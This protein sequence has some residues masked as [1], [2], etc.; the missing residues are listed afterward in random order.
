MVLG[1]R[2]TKD[3][4]DPRFK[5]FH[6]LMRK[7]IHDILLVSTLYDACI[8]EEDG[9]LA[10]RIF[11]EYRGL[12]LSQPPRLT[13]ASSGEEALRCLDEKEFDLVL[14]MRRLADMDSYAFGE[15]LKRKRPGLPVIL[16]THTA[17]DP[18]RL[19][20]RPPGIDRTFVWTGNDELLL[21]LVKSVEDQMNVDHDIEVAG[22]RVILFVEDSPLYLS[23]LLPVVFK[24]VMLQTQAVMEQGLNEEHKLLTMRARPKILVAE[25]F[26]EATGLYE[27]Y[28]QYLLG[29]ISDVRFPRECELD[30]EGGI[31]FLSRIGREKPDVPLLLA[32]SD[33]SNAEK[34]ARIGARFINKNSPSLNAEVRSFLTGRLGFGDFVFRLPDG[35]VIA[36]V[37]NMYEFEKALRTIPPESFYYHW[38][39]ND[40]SR[41]LFARSEIILASK[42]R[43]VT[44]A[45][46]M[47]D[48][49]GMRQF[50]VSNINERRKRR[51]KGI[52]ASFEATD[53]DP[54][55]DFMKIGKGSV[56]GKARGLAFISRLLYWD[57]DLQ[58]KH[59][60]VSIMFPRTLVVT[61][62]GF[63]A[64]MELNGFMGF[65]ETRLSDAQIANLFLKAEFPTWLRDKLGV[66]LEHADYPLAIRSSSLLEDNQLQPYAGLYR[67]YMVPNSHRDISRRLD[68]LIAAVKLVYASTY[69]EG[70]RAFTGRA[71]RR[72]EEEK[73]AVLIQRLVGKRYGNHFY[74]AIS[75]IAQSRNYY[76]VP[77]M[78]PEEGIAHIALGLGKTVMEGGRVL[79]FSPRYPQMHPQFSGVDDILKNAQR[80]FYALRMNDPD[81]IVDIREESTLEKREVSDARH[82]E[83]V[84]LLTSTYIPEEHSL[85]DGDLKSGSKVLTFAQVLKYRLFPLAEILTDVMEACRS[86]MGGPVELEFSVNL[87]PVGGCKPEFALLQIRPM[88]F[89]DKPAEVEI[90]AE[91]VAGAFCHSTHALG[92]SHKQ[93]M[94][95]IVYVKPDAFEPGHMLEISREISAVNAGFARTGRKYLLIGPGRWGSA[96]RWLGIPVD[97]TDISGVGAIVETTASQLQVEPSQGSHFFHNITTLGID[98]IMVTQGGG[99]VLDWAW[100]QSLPKVEETTHVARVRLDRPYVLKVDG[101]RSLCVIRVQP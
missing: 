76:P 18:S 77:P 9:R 52:L 30:D 70:P 89:E 88:A 20:R 6:E 14:T 16:L 55:T 74:P 51:Q 41:W 87:C 13:W 39:H 92:H 72:V 37:P 4:F 10:E 80:Y 46:F 100:L 1:I 78:K 24:E 57:P 32:S 59:A 19:C 25:N 22:V 99:D 7:K 65:S 64:F 71:P 56:G 11:H 68:Q 12:S 33:P 79:R 63:D 44:D 73:M 31:V 47:G 48:V 45:D 54:D 3:E 86:G 96:D 94:T 60:D 82:E 29:V 2:Q 53:F 91:D 26:E 75:G 84:E 42:F 5:I 66:Y 8:L 27:R 93:D 98:Y 28:E 58:R 21:A 35:R 17:P 38:S 69:F 49:E 62:E 85:R 23:A 40:F 97:W 95:D 43:P 83:P 67:T 15:E 61:T 34:A 101:S 90:T 36:R 81:L 50:V